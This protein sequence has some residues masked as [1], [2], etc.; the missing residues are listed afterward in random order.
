MAD[1]VLIALIAGA[2]ALA[3][4]Y[5]NSF[6]A[7][8][9]RRFRDGSALAASL[10][11]E[12]A[13]YEP[14]WPIITKMLDS[15]IESVDAGARKPTYLR[16]FD[17]PNDLVFE[18]AVGKLGLLGARSAENVVFVYSNLR[19]FRVALELICRYEKEMSNEE[20]RF[21]CV[22]CKEA[23]G[24]AVS[25]GTDL[26]QELRQRS[27]QAFVPEWPWAVWAGLLQRHPTITK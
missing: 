27:S 6:V 7:E 14:A 8:S 4:A 20:L 21:R 2:V 24:R 26:L 15:I 9:Y 1:S 17:R 10:A 5:V 11:G 23:I 22:A 16:P 3:V 12:L 13:A 19:A 18:N 25:R